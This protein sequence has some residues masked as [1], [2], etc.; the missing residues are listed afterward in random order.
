LAAGLQLN[1]KAFAGQRTMLARLTFLVFLLCTSAGHG[2]RRERVSPTHVPTDASVADTGDL[3][4]FEGH[5]QGDASDLLWTILTGDE[6][7]RLRYPCSRS[8]PDGLDGTWSPTS[9]DVGKAES[10]LGDALDAAFRRLPIGI[11]AWRPPRYMRQYAGFLRN[12]RKVLYVNGTFVRATR[13]W[14]TVAA[15]MCDGA[16]KSFGAVFDFD[17]DAFDSFEFNGGI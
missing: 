11:E 17:R 13:P 1:A 5:R 6:A 14:R 9:V 10:R 3:A 2:C 12:G 7:E 4:T 15:R 8:F 16:T